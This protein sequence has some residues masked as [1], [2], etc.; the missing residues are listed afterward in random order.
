VLLDLSSAFDTIDYSIMGSILEN[1]FGI[2]ST[3]L[4]WLMSFLSPRQQRVVIDNVQSRNFP[5]FSGVP[6]GSC[7]GP[8]LFIIYA[9]RL[10]RIAQKHLPS[11]QSYADDTQLYLSFRPSSESS[12]D[13]AIKAIEASIVDLRAWM[14]SHYLQLNDAKT[15]FMIIGSQ[16]QLSKVNIEGVLVGS[17]VIK[18]AE[19][20]RNLGT[21]FDNTMSMNIHV[22]KVCSK[23]FH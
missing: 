9:S 11:V 8:I 14:S 12:A 5:L 1:D 20:V 17:S 2:T 19:S 16:H 6:Q 4:S 15:E 7:L 21:W 22:G 3:A 23:A 13:N 18:P 10:F